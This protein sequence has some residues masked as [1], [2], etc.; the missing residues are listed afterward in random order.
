MSILV[1]IQNVKGQIKKQ[2]FELTAYA[3]QLAQKMGGSIT[4]IVIGEID[5]EHLQQLGKYGMTKVIKVGDA[6]FNT[7]FNGVYT[8]I[9]EQV[10][11]QEAARV[12]LFPD[13]NLGKALGPRLSV[14][15]KAG[16]VPEVMALPVSY[17]PFIVTKRAFTGRA[18]ANVQVN[19]SRKILSLMINA[20]GINENPVELSF[21]EFQPQLDRTTS[22]LQLVNRL[23]Y[24]GG[25][26]LVDADIV[27]SG[28]RGM[29]GGEN[30]AMLEELAGTLGAA[31]ACSRPV[32]DDGWRSP[33]EHVGQTGKIIA[34]KIYF[35]V[36]ISG[37]IQHVAGVSGS[38][39]LVAINSD[40]DAP[41]F[42]VADYG[43]VGDAFKV[44]PELTA[45]FKAHLASH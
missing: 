21:Q 44:I 24:E 8:R 16:F 37:A 41:I 35:A 19:S 26:N 1:Y 27:V 45:V 5:N 18:L 9:I 29:K 7:R 33:D 17:D 10:A 13:N 15:L 6:V 2:S 12:V 30:W 39:C 40:P 32:A 11:K 34:P 25:V 14:R 31:L 3:W 38:K 28:G 42:D 20:F 4:G 36:G 43:I 23:V 22:R